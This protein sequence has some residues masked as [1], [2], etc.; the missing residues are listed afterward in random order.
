MIS[1]KQLQYFDCLAATGHSGRAAGRA[2]VSQPALSMQI[3]EL[4]R[5]LDG[6]LVE[7]RPDG[8]RLTSLGQEMASRVRRI[9]AEV[10]DLESLADAQG[11][12]L[13]GPL[14]L[15]II[16]SVAPFLL[17]P[18]LGLLA[19][20]HPQL[21]MTVRETVTET[22]A[23][24]LAAGSLDVVVASLPLEREDLEEASAFED[25]FLLAVHEGS[26]HAK[27]TPALADLIKADEL[28]L[29]EDGHC[30]RDQ[31]LSVCRAIDPARLR[32]FGATS[33]S[34]L[35][36]LVGAG[37]GV[38]LLPEMAIDAGIVVDPRLRLN[39]F[40]TPEP[41]RVV[42]VAWRRRS[43]REGDYRVLAELVREASGALGDG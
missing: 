12:I 38:T 8:A 13:S 22:L 9:L 5:S 41:S 31:A 30:F 29:L 10:Q 34:T 28:L 11:D 27:R 32:S 19:E 24:E 4:E 26:E 15:G 40:A 14:R 1:L 35:L 37:H 3:K 17:P 39:R 36:Q 23:D 20:R 21:R 25:R 43:P 33:F 2:G 42:G 6:Q 16:P 7:R 18:L